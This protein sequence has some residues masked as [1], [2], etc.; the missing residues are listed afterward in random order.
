MENIRLIHLNINSVLSKIDEL[1]EIAN[2][3]RAAVIG[4]TKT[5]L[6]ADVLDV[7]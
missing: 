6:D 4:L 3:T 7:K 5:K 1:G 2:E